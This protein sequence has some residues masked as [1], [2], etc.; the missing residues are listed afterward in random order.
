MKALHLR[1]LCVLACLLLVAAVY[2]PGLRGPFL[3]DDFPNIVDNPLVAI[4]SLDAQSLRNAA[5]SNG[6]GPLGRPLPA[7]SFALNYYF[8]GGRF[9]PFAY[10]LTNLCVHL[11]NVL[12]VLVLARRLLPRLGGGVELPSWLG[13]SVPVLA[14]ALWGLHPLQLT[15][16]LYVVQRMN[17]LAS[18]FVLAGLIGWVA[19]RER[20]ARGERG[21]AALM[22]LSTGAGM[23]LG[24][25]C[26][27]NAVLLAPLAAALELTLYTRQDMTRAG[28]AV[29]VLYHGLFLVAPLVIA[30][31]W[32]VLHPQVVHDAYA[33][34]PFTA[35]ERVLTELRVLWFYLGELLLPLP[36]SLSLF[37]DD[38]RVSHDLLHPATTLVALIAWLALIALAW[39]GHRH[40]RPLLAFAVAW[41]L[42]GHALESTIFPLELVHEYRNYLASVGVLLAGVAAL[43][44]LVATAR[45]RRGPGL[46]LLAT[47]ALA[48]GVVTAARAYTWGDTG[49]F[50]TTE[51][52]HHP[53][54]NRVQ[55][56]YAEYALQRGRLG[57]A[58]EHYRIAASLSRRDVGS[59]LQMARLAYQL[60]AALKAGG[61]TPQPGDSA[62][63]P[64]GYDDVLVARRAY[65]DA[66]QP[67]LYREIGRR[68]AGPVVPAATV[69]A[70]RKLRACMQRRDASCLQMRGEASRW[71]ARL[72]KRG[73]L[74]AT[75]RAGF[76]FE[77][78]RVL[79][80]RGAPAREVLAWLARARKLDPT[81]VQVLVYRTLYLIETGR[82][83]AATRSL[84]ALSA[85]HG[86][87]GFRNEDLRA[88]RKR[89]KAARAAHRAGDTSF[90]MGEGLA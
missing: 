89:L 42:A 53:A 3:F 38:F 6:S 84:A 82:L 67:M 5:L 20:L 58:Y 49:R 13:A 81:G 75:R 76:A 83:D 40:G 1:P 8:A 59:L 69:R 16:V 11:L 46:A 9:D 30:L 90:G 54:S 21:G 55:R 25:L 31:G 78:A 57:V 39:R 79:A 70:L 18:F 86:R 85:Q 88:L 52:M 63:R 15:S 4:T 61:L 33:Q 72:A 24:L 17:S 32:L 60:D 47:L 77:T 65:L 66:L 50:I 22:F 19:G 45:I 35:G 10:K 74:G 34:R 43:A 71:L 62:R 27:E 29:V 23:G 56:G 2:V 28:R 44:R 80:L 41:Y 37:H 48:P 51:L 73:D 87:I 7:L 26:K 36:S 64:R 12:L 68:L 14:A